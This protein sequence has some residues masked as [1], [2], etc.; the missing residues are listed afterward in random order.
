MRLSKRLLN[1]GYKRMRAAKDALR[2]PFRL[3]KHRHGLAEIIQSSAF[4]I[5]ERDRAI[6]H[7]PECVFIR[8]TAKTSRYG[9]RFAKH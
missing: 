3:L 2:S 9:Y 1:S 4:V 7:Q 5:V 8:F 6:P